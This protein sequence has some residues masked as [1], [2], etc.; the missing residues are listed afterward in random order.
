[1][2]E[3]ESLATDEALDIHVARHALDRLVMFSDGVFAIATTLA[4]LEIRLP[5]GVRDPAEALRLMARPLFAYGLSFLVIAIFWLSH[6][7]LFARVARV[8][9]PLTALTLAFLFTISLIPLGVGGIAVRAANAGLRTYLATMFACGL[10]NSAMWCYASLAP[11]V[12]RRD[13]PLEYRW[14]R[15]V[16]SW[17]M[18][19][20]FV[21]LLVVP[22]GQLEYAVLGTAIALL[23]V[24][25]RVLPALVRRKIAGQSPAA[26][27]E[28]GAPATP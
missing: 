22:A 23:V 2:G 9:R 4:A 18:P 11:G 16:G 21:P 10:I 6:R 3:L 26:A 8:T 27:V 20:L 7:D 13:V 14:T 5:Q 15:A 24:R 17:A 12:M 25:R 1:M 28:Q 19:L